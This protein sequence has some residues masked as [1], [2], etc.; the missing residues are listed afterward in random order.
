[1]VVTQFL[2]GE[3]WSGKL[4]NTAYFIPKYRLDPIYSDAFLGENT[5]E[6]S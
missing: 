1:M 2:M 6:V 5:E 3:D 4:R